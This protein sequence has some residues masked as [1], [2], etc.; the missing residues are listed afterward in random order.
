MVLLNASGLGI[1]FELMVTGMITVFIMLCLVVLIGRVTI[2]IINKFDKTPEVAK[3]YIDPNAISAN[4]IIA[5][6]TAVNIVTKGKAGGLK[7]ERV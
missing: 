2:A 3:K 6:T 5:I 4:Q 1:A 7:I